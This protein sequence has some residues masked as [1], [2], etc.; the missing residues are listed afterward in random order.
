MEHENKISYEPPVNALLALGEIP[1]TGEWINYEVYGLSQEHVA[2]LVHMA[3][4]EYLH[5]SERQ[6]PELWAPVHAWR[7]LGQ[8]RASK[9]VAPLL[10]L[11]DEYRDNDWIHEEIPI[12]I[13]MIGAAAI[14][15]TRDFLRELHRDLY[16][17][18]GAAHGLEEIGKKDPACRG[19]CVQALTTALDNS[20][21]QTIEL[22]AFLI[23]SLISLEAREAAELIEQVFA[24]EQVDISIV[25]DWEDVQV[26]LG[27]L[28]ERL[29]PSPNYG[30]MG[31]GENWG[32]DGLRRLLSI[33][34]QKKRV[35]KNRKKR[36]AAKAS[37]KKNRKKSR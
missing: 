37:R 10:G 34:T 33:T 24:A 35:E 8:L 22:N 26:E 30:T 25:G 11:I 23:G 3:T 17:L 14:A 6:E 16:A 28:Q 19:D 9:A 1:F 36:K 12:V 18:A 15:P 7:A 5:S 20:A 4:D 21:Q 2:T 31:D 29:T 32:E 27:L 13:G